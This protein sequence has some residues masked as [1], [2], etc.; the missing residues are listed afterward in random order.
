MPTKRKL[1]QQCET[2][3]DKVPH[4]IRQRY[5]N[6]FTE[7]FLKTTTNVNDAF[8]KVSLCHLNSSSLATVQIFNWFHSV[9]VDRHLLRR[10]LCITAVWTNSNIWA[11]QWMHWRGW[12]TKVLL[13]LKVK[14][15]CSRNA[16][17]M[18]TLRHKLVLCNHSYVSGADENEVNSQRFK[19]N[20]P[21]NLKKL[22][23][24]GED[25]FPF[26][27]FHSNILT[28]SQ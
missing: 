9:I 6:M 18:L 27:A 1:K 3:K 28:A 8:E 26:N 13:L 12:R 2:A 4:D 22:K 16:W 10:R 21:L 11:L 5:V 7:E 23:G 25:K 15:K 17:M 24:N 20:I 19:G 14:P